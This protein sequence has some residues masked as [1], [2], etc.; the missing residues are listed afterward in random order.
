MC[1]V[2]LFLLTYFSAVEDRI[3]A[4]IV[5]VSLVLLVSRGLIAVELFRQARQRSIL[6][7]FA[8]LMAAYA[9]FGAISDTVAGEPSVH[10]HYRVVLSADAEQ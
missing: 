6:N 2:A 9:L 10:L 4:R 7:V 8:A 3:A 5:I 1:V